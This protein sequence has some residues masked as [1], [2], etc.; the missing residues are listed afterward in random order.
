MELTAAL[1]RECAHWVG[2]ALERYEAGGYRWHPTS[3]A[4]E[5][6]RELQQYREQD[7]PVFYDGNA[8]NLYGSAMANT[9]FRAWHDAVHLSHGLSFKA[10]DERMVGWLQYCE[11]RKLGAP[12]HVAWLVY[13]DVVS[14]VDY[15][16]EH[17][18]FV[19]D[20]LA[21]INQLIA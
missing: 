16:A 2:V 13:L 21:F 18:Q 10:D 1:Q 8:K 19:P 17:K 7:V 14:Q 4:P 9:R 15:Y 5:T 3:K 6:W 20:Q 12:A 11:L